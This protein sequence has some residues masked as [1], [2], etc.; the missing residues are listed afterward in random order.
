MFSP[1]YASCFKSVSYEGTENKC[2]Q[3]IQ[4][5]KVAGALKMK[6]APGRRFGHKFQYA[7]V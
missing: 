7:K 5:E 3:L 6:K 1:E 2:V 4:N